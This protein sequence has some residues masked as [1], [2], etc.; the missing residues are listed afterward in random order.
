METPF[1]DL[2]F[3]D[4]TIVNL[5]AEYADD[6]IV[7]DLI[8]SSLNTVCIKLAQTL[9]LEPECA[10]CTM[11]AIHHVDADVHN[12]MKGHL[13]SLQEVL[14]ENEGYKIKIKRIDSCSCE[15]II[16]TLHKNDVTLEIKTL[17]AKNRTS[18]STTEVDNF[19]KNLDRMKTSG[20]FMAVNM[21]TLWATAGKKDLEIQNL[22]NGRFAVYLADNDC[23]GTDVKTI[24][25]LIHRLEALSKQLPEK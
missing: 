18:V 24:L 21:P 5:F 10:H 1:V 19:L 6:R 23:D 12:G 22:S 15:L 20:I 7:T 25:L 13:A 2:R 14:Q 8:L 11:I 16:E 3:T 4:P 17:G 9:T